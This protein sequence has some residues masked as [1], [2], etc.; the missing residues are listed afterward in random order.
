MDAVIEQSLV[1]VVRSQLE[2]ERA[3][4]RAQLDQL[5]ED[6]DAPA[7][8]DDNF[9]DSG[10]VQA[11]RDEVS[12]LANQLRERLVDVED[13]SAKLDDGTYGLCERCG[14]TIGEARLEAMPATRYC[15]EHA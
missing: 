10:Q 11:E 3:Q 4:L 9:A 6:G 15:I 5:G 8:F 14:A 12:A 1:S 13:A 2:A 7:D